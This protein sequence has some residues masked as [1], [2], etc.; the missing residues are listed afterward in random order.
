MPGARSVTLQ[1]DPILRI[2][3]AG[4]FA[5]AAADRRLPRPERPSLPGA[6]GE[7]LPL[8]RRSGGEPGDQSEED[9]D[10][11]DFDDAVDSD[12]LGEDEPEDPGS[13]VELLELDEESLELDEE[14]F[15]SWRLLGP[16]ADSFIS[17]ARLRVP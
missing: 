5:C 1:S 2:R 10:E 15:L 12:L 4:K 9:L 11:E 16:S 7:H 14:S 13:E 17:R 6:P 8:G 3:R